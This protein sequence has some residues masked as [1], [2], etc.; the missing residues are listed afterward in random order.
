[1]PLKFVDMLVSVQ[2]QFTLSSAGWHLQFVF[3]SQLRFIVASLE[4][5]CS[6]G[7]FF[8][9][10]IAVLLPFVTKDVCSAG[11]GVIVTELSAIFMVSNS[12]GIVGWSV[13][14]CSTGPSS[15]FIIMTCSALFSP[16]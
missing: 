9:V 7:W 15:G 12:W 5:H 6:V 8:A 10:H 2:T 16:S 3:R 13:T 4:V 14:V 1:M 11:V